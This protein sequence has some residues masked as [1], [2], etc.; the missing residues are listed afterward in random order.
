VVADRTTRW[1]WHADKLL[2]GAALAVCAAAVISFWHEGPRP[3]DGPTL[4]ARAGF[5]FDTAERLD[6]RLERSLPDLSVDIATDPD[7][8]RPRPG[9]HVCLNPECIY[10]VPDSEKWCP[11]CGAPQD[12]ADFDGMDDAF[13]RRHTATN[14]EVADGH[15]DG[16]GDNFTNKEEY[17]AGS[18]PDDPKSVPAPIR[19]V[20]IERELIDVLFRGYA[21]S[22]S[23]RTEIQ[24]NWGNDT[25]TTILPLGSTFRGYHLEELRTDTGKRGEPHDSLILKRPEGDALVL[26]RSTPVREPERYGVFAAADN[27][28]ERAR[29]YPG[30][31]FEIEGCSY[32]VVEITRTGARLI[33]DRGERISLELTR[34]KSR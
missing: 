24:L 29:A 26:P 5:E 14:P 22:R 1:L 34:I 10:I 20:A 16:D 12:D 25:R 4:S 21:L 9:E 28:T 7:E 11:K 19:L 18:D 6:F 8:Y 31:H 30:M 17:D 3:S 27:P 15:L 33:G 2:F 13:E 23:G 32:L